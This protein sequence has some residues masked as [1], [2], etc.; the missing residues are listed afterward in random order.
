MTTF[1]ALK[2]SSSTPETIQCFAS[3]H[4]SEQSSLHGVTAAGSLGISWSTAEGIDMD[5]WDAPPSIDVAVGLYLDMA[6]LIAFSEDPV[7]WTA[8]VSRATDARKAAED[9]KEVDPRQ[10]SAVPSQQLACWTDVSICR[11]TGVPP[12]QPLTTL[13]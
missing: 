6:D 2:T 9:R 4:R 7:Q 12:P 1:A 3:S 13:N 11:L 8:A 5:V 10:S